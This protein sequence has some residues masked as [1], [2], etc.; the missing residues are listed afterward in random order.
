MYVRKFV[1]TLLIVKTRKQAECPSIVEHL[2]NSVDSHYG[3]LYGNA[4]NKPLHAARKMNFSK[5]ILSKRSW[6]QLN[7]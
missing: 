7:I 6:T 5:K 1:A 4:M 3:I 2:N